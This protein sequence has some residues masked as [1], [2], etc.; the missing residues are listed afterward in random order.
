MSQAASTSYHVAPGGSCPTPSLSSAIPE[1]LSLVTS[2]GMLGLK[3]AEA[4]SGPRESRLYR[5]TL[6]LLPQEGDGLV[7]RAKASSPSRMRKRVGATCPVS[8]AS[9][10]A[11]NVSALRW[12]LVT[13]TFFFGPT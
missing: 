12:P 4:I 2:L 11:R 10:V 5:L 8:S 7:T 13:E 3:P 1:V 6:T 9:A